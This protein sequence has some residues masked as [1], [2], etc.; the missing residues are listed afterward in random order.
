MQKLLR[1]THGVV[2]LE[3]SWTVLELQ[4]RAG[5]AARG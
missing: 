1:S 3:V 4:L 2:V 5:G